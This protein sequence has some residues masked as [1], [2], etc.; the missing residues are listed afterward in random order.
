MVIT[1]CPLASALLFETQA[2]N[3]H[4]Q[5]C[6]KQ[7]GITAQTI[8]VIQTSALGKRHVCQGEKNYINWCWLVM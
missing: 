6:D 1:L 7:A 2:E 5:C 4:Q 3:R 8:K